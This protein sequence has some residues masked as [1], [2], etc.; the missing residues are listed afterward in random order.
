MTP[1]DKAYIAFIME[2]LKEAWRKHGLK[3]NP[4]NLDEAASKAGLGYKTFEAYR[5]ARHRQ[6]LLQQLPGYMEKAGRKQRAKAKD[7][8]AGQ[9]SLF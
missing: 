4:K 3:R 7:E 2:P 1:D 8:K 9:G 5:V 6:W